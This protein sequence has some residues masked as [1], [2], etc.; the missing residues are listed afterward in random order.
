[1]VPPLR[2][3]MLLSANL[4]KLFSGEALRGDPL[5]F[6]VPLEDVT[7][8]WDS[9]DGDGNQPRIDEFGTTTTETATNHEPMGM[10]SDD[11]D[12]NHESTA[13]VHRT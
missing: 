3:Y 7:M 5:V 13:P 4:H 1:M 6:K 11:R 10:D 12:G 8:A 2:S 9:D